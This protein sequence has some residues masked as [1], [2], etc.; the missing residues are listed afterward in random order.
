MFSAY[1]D[2]CNKPLHREVMC[3]IEKVAKASGSNFY[4]KQELK[5]LKRVLTL[6]NSA[7]IGI[8]LC[9][10]VKA[11]SDDDLY[12]GS[13]TPRVSNVIQVSECKAFDERFGKVDV[14]LGDIKGFINRVNVVPGRLC[15]YKLVGNDSPTM[16]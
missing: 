5:R 9:A 3:D 16:I 2:H 15:G 13:N 4:K 10:A 7:D 8:D 12:G 11:A 14:A 6:G 1:S